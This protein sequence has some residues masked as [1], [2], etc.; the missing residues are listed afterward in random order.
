VIVKLSANPE[1]GLT[2]DE[3]SYRELESFEWFR[4]I[5]KAL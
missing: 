2:N 3:S 4:A 5:I 1:Y